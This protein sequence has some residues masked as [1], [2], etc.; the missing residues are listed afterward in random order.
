MFYCRYIDDIFLISTSTE[1]NFNN[2]IT[3]LNTKHDSIK[4]DHE[5]SK[6]SI[7]FLDT[8]I[9]IDNDRK[10][11]TTL[12]KKLTDTDNYVHYQ[13]SHP[14]HLKDS[15]PYSQALRIKHVCSKDIEFDKNCTELKNSFSKS[16]FTWENSCRDEFITPRDFYWFV[17]FRQVYMEISSRVSRV[18]FEDWAVCACVLWLI[19]PLFCGWANF[20]VN[21]NGGKSKQRSCFGYD[22]EKCPITAQCCTPS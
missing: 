9:Y 2:F 10:I 14:W 4:F 6:T 18:C 20:P 12:F 21:Q 11:Q 22:A 5:I 15:P 16:P 17:I 19:F 8:R 1:E 7:S 13:S 3:Q